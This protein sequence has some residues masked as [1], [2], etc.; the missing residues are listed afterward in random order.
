MRTI[1]VIANKKKFKSM[2][3]TQDDFRQIEQ[4]FQVRT[5]RDT[6]FPYTDSLNKED[7][8]AIVQDAVNKQIPVWQL[9]EEFDRLHKEALLILSNKSADYKITLKEAISKVPLD[10]RRPG[11]FITFCNE[12]CNWVVYQFTGLN[13]K[14]WGNINYWENPFSVSFRD[15]VPTA[16]EEDITEVFKDKT[17]YLRFKDRRYNPLSYIDKGRIILRRNLQFLDVCTEDDSLVTTNPLTQDLL[18]EA[19]TTYV[20]RYTFDLRG[21]TIRIPSGCSLEFEGG[22]INNG[23]IVLDNTDIFGIHALSEFGSN[24]AVVGKFADG[25]LIYRDNT[26]D[27]FL[28]VNIDSIW[29]KLAKDYDLQE[30]KKTVNSIY[31][32]KGKANGIAS[33]DKNGKVPWSQLPDHPREVLEYPQKSSFPEIGESQKIYIDVESGDIYR[34]S[35]A[36]YEVLSKLELGE[37]PG[38]AYDGAKGA[39]LAD[40]VDNNR[41]SITNLGS[42]IDEV[43]QRIDSIS[44]GSSDVNS[45]INNIQNNITD[46]EESI[47]NIGKELTKKLTI[48]EQL[49]YIEDPISTLSIPFNTKNDM[50]GNIYEAKG[51]STD[52]PIAIDLSYTLSPELGGGTHNIENLPPVYDKDKLII[53]N[54]QDGTRPNVVVIPYSANARI[55]ALQGK[56]SELETKV[57]DGIGGGGSEI[58]TELRNRIQVLEESNTLLEGEVS[59]LQ[60]ENTSIKANIANLATLIEELTNR[61]ATL[62]SEK[63]AIL[64][65]NNIIEVQLSKGQTTAQVNIDVIPDNVDLNI[66]SDNTNINVS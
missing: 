11:L 64:S 40:E 63:L 28:Y 65:P 7:T 66:E 1:H 36:Q 49:T 33:L 17:H 37:T 32:E 8:V 9:M 6:D 39:A 23:S 47:T 51:T 3:F 59:T 20:I 57:E 41:E 16:D 50:V 14:Q 54:S 24:I 18:S 29:Y 58:L 48:G 5:K 26:D 19:N 56:V 45:T 34:W 60:N 22:T 44:Q 25:Q 43:N 46:I 13:T 52:T 15:L 27:K 4:W 61:V 35:G 30:L 38:T 62:E 31:A 42:R 12:N 53:V 21:E 2:F 55:T 10:K